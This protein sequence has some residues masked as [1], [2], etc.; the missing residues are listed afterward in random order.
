VGIDIIEV[1]R[2]ED[3]LNRTPGLKE[4]L[5]TPLEMSYCES[6]K[7]PYQHYAGRFA[8][9][10]AFFKALGTGWSQGVKFREVEIRNL[11]SGQPVI[12]VYG[13]TRQLCQSKG[14]SH[15]HVSLSHLRTHAVATVIIE[16]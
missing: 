9:K 15:F 6:K 14:V 2:V 10:E 8:A 5:Y 3:K 4:K 11:E 12:E 1:S 16:K 7:F 13:Q